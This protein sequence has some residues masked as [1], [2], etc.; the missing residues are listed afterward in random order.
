MPAKKSKQAA[1]P[2][3][4]LDPL[5]I[6]ACNNLRRASRA[7]TQ[8]FD[9]TLQA[10][11]LR[12]TRLVILLAIMQSDTAGGIAQL[13]RTLGMDASTLNRNLRPLKQRRL[14][15]VEQGKT[16]QRKRV[17]LTEIGRK[18]IQDATPAWQNAQERVIADLGED[19][20]HSLLAD[21][22]A[23]VSATRR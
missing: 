14:V 12:S 15:K 5:A 17:S 13:A 6:C 2:A 23:I 8:F 22:D 1:P 19:R 7:V 11:G 21:L 20:Y 3:E 9:D 10:S 4:G 18:A 16:G